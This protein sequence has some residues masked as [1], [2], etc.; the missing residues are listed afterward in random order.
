MGCGPSKSDLVVVQDVTGMTKK[1]ASESFSRFKKEAGGSKIKL[2]KFTKLVSSLNTNKGDAT[3]YSKHL[4]RVLD[5]DK[6]NMVSWKEVMVGFHQLSPSGDPDQKLRLVYNMYDVKG[7]KSVTMDEVKMITQAQFKLQGWPL[8]DDD[9]DKRV[10]SCFNQVRNSIL[11]YLILSNDQSICQT[12]YFF[13]DKI[14]ID[15][16]KKI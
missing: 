10:K 9:I 1:D 3:E 6:D 16:D 12:K 5:T 15:G 14:K 4:F 11:I 7:D 2:D 13:K 8:K